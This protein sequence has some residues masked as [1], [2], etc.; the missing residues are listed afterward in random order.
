MAS[1]R[2]MTMANLRIYLVYLPY[3]LLTTLAAVRAAVALS[4]RLVK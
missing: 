3:V 4:L 2:G 1:I